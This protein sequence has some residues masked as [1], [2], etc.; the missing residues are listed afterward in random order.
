[1]ANHL[2][3]LSTP[4]NIVREMIHQRD[5]GGYIAILSWRLTETVPDVTIAR[6]VMDAVYNNK[7]L[8]ECL[9]LLQTQTEVTR[10]SDY[11][12]ETSPD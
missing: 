11:H 1:M 5:N 10:K 4:E 6:R 7:S 3:D 9:A 12:K 2:P 8:E